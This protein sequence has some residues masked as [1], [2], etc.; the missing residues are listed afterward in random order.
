M[1]AVLP[2]RVRV[3][4]KEA[5]FLGR[6]L[7]GLLLGLEPSQLSAGLFTALQ[8]TR[9][10]KLLICSCGKGTRDTAGENS[11]ESKY[12]LWHRS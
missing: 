3:S 1:V 10:T 5:F 12:Q 4:S 2:K 7:A 9:F 8:H 6:R 11:Q